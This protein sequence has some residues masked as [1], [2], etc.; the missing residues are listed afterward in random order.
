[1]AKCMCAVTAC[2]VE[3][4]RKGNLERANRIRYRRHI[5]LIR[6]DWRNRGRGNGVKWTEMI[7]SDNTVGDWNLKAFGLI[8]AYKSVELSSVLV[9]RAQVRRSRK[10]SL[11]DSV[12]GY[13]TQR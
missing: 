7:A 9:L 11:V 13:G 5:R 8:E 2:Q 6:V 1:M 10:R 12:W 3:K 4:R